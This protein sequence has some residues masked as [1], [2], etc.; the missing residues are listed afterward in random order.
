[1]AIS[2]SEAW[3]IVKFFDVW[4]KPVIASITLGS[5]KFVCRK[6]PPNGAVGY[7]INA[8]AARVL[9]SRKRIF[10]PVDE[11]ISRPW[12]FDLRVWSTESNLVT[13]ISKSHGGSL[14][15]EE[16]KQE[17]IHQRRNPIRN[18]LVRNTLELYKLISS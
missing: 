18:V 7:L 12:E 1:D 9:L 15:E 6:Y 14:L 3:D 5:T 8:N 4:S 13:E 11:D 2:R 17:E 10:R 16:R